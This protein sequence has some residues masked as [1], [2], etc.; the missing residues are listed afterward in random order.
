MVPKPTE[1]LVPFFLVRLSAYP[2]RIK[3]PSENHSVPPFRKLPFQVISPWYWF[4]NPL[5]NEP[6]SGLFSLHSFLFFL[7]SVLS[8]EGDRVRTGISDCTS[9]GREVLPMVPQRP[10]QIRSKQRVR[11]RSSHHISF[12][13]TIPWWYLNLR[14]EFWVRRTTLGLDS[15]RG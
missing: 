12:G 8:Q 11:L 1:T 6:I 2:T 7:N 13:K 4:S 3:W 14:K 5:R 9:R 15:W 10:M